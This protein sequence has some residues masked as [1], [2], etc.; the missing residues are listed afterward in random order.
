MHG[1]TWGT[2]AVWSSMRVTRPCPSSTRIGV[3]YGHMGLTEDVTPETK[4]KE[5]TIAERRK[6]IMSRMRELLR[7]IQ[8]NA[9]L[10][11]II[12]Y[13]QLFHF[14][15]ESN[16][17]RRTHALSI[18]ISYIIAFTFSGW[19]KYIAL[20]YHIYIFSIFSG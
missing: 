17:V 8:G 2:L 3:G 7:L 6:S 14:Q 19:I 20:S 1:S 18:I 15:I 13:L 16:L 4:T 12:S 11:A 5:T 9:F 10:S